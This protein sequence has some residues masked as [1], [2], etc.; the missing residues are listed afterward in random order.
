MNNYAEKSVVVILE[1]FR[2]FQN[3]KINQSRIFFKKMMQ[4]FEMAMATENSRNFLLIQQLLRT[5][6]QSLWKNLCIRFAHR[7]DFIIFA[8]N[9]I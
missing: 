2:V 1:A 8:R 3:K 9:Y 7:I 4:G 6:G 5:F